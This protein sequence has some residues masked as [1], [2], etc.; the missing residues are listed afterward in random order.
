MATHTTQA[1]VRSLIGATLLASLT[2]AA[3]SAQIPADVAAAAVFSERIDQYARLRGRL[4]EPL[5]PL[6]D[7]RGAWPVMLTRRYLAG[8]IRAARPQTRLGAIFAPPVDGLFRR[9]IAAR[10]DML[11]VE[12][13]SGLDEDLGVVIVANEPVPDWSLVTVPEAVAEAFP[14][15]P[16]GIDYRLVNG[17]LVL[18]DTH[19]QIVIDALPDAFVER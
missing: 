4:Q 11:D 2:P 7:R 10:K 1:V 18:W 16:S 13:L 19:A 15:L 6:D 17:A 3:A 12:G 9:V 5:P 8:A 14:P